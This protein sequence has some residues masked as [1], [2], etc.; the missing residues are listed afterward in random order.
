MD[1]V[2]EPL[3]AF[4]R[5][6]PI[7]LPSVSHLTAG[8][9]SLFPESS[10]QAIRESVKMQKI[11]SFLLFV[12]LLHGLALG[13]EAPIEPPNTQYCTQSWRSTQSTP[14]LFQC[15]TNPNTT[16]SCKTCDTPV[17]YGGASNCYRYLNQ[18]TLKGETDDTNVGALLCQEYVKKD[19]HLEWWNSEANDAD[20]YSL[21]LG[22]LIKTPTPNFEALR[23]GKMQIVIKWGGI[24]DKEDQ[25]EGLE[26]GS[27]GD[28]KFDG[29]GG[30]IKS[31]ADKG[32]KI[33]RKEDDHGKGKCD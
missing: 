10:N 23:L 32:K 1:I 26:I 21:A 15:M 27:L 29:V 14:K 9:L 18:T 24:G 25:M 22:P 28:E 16:Y 17:P 2:S 30:S 4:M 31:W 20:G 8:F 13:K 3:E 6:T 11:V 5:T 33:L 19:D 7:F 12:C